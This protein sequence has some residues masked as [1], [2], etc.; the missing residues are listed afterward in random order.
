MGPHILVMSG[1]LAF[2]WIMWYILSREQDNDGCLQKLFH[3]TQVATY[4]ATG[5]IICAMLPNIISGAPSEVPVVAGDHPI[6]GFNV[7]TI[8][9]MWLFILMISTTFFKS[10]YNA[11]YMNRISAVVGIFGVGV[12]TVGLTVDFFG[13]LPDT[14][15]FNL[16]L[17]LI[18]GALRISSGVVVFMLNQFSMCAKKAGIELRP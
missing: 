17:M 11:G 1:M 16:D 10:D 5:A 13:G 7:A 18:I 4:A 14:T 3:P 2:V 8:A 6:N 15:T 9:C 12:V